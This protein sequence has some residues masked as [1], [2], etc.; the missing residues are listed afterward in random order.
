MNFVGIIFRGR[1]TA[2]FIPR[3]G[4]KDYNDESIYAEKKR[5]LLQGL[6]ERKLVIPIFPK[7]K[8]CCSSLPPIRKRSYKNLYDSDEKRAIFIPS[9]GMLHCKCV[10]HFCNAK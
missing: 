4:K 8:E 5:F 7:T 9:I 2:T 1:Q 6:K 3:F 10:K